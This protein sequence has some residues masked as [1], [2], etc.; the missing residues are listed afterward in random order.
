MYRIVL[1]LL[2]AIQPLPQAVQQNEIKDALAHAEAL[3]YG[4]RFGESIA[5]L[6][7]I[8]DALKTQTGSVP[9]KINTKLKLALAH[10]GLNETAKAKAYLMEVFALD[11]N[12]S[13]DPQQFPP[14]VLAVA[15]E[16]KTEQLKVECYTAQTDA[17]GYLESGKTTALL[18]LM[19]S[20]GPKCPALTAMA[21]EAAESFY[22]TGVA[23]YRAGDFSKA[24]SNFDAAVT[25][26][27]EHEMAFQYIDLTRSKLQVN[28]DRLLLDWQKS[29]EAH[30]WPAAAA[31]YRQIISSNNK[32]AINRVNGEYRKSLSAL[33]ESWNR[34]CPNYDQAKMSAIRSQISELL[35]E[36]S[37]GADI[38]GQ[39]VACPEPAKAAPPTAVASA[40][41][42]A[43]VVKPAV[44]DSTKPPTPAPTS[45]VDMQ[46]QLAL[47]RLKTRVDPAITNEVRYYLKSNTQIVVHV[48]ARISESGDV[49]VMSMSDGHPLLNS[50]VRSAVTQWKFTPIRDQSG[51]RCVDTDIPIVIKLA[52]Q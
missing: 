46:S 10:I 8:D 16:A 20:R 30:Q 15:A 2:T 51:A 7:R 3:Y 12:Y 47:T 4:A 29:F 33:V 18:D 28:Q 42:V 40:D 43:P 26:A 25:L 1:A 6:T 37:F 36:P 39:M 13:L 38:R 34:S 27:P 24:L 21:P 31:G 22:R 44:P 17:R 49:T 19:R 9:D 48:K 32:D 23:A 41:N 5:L 11:S 50:A 35:P 14:K 52:S 45:C